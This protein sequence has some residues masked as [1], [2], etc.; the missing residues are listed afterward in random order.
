MLVLAAAWRDGRLREL[1]D[2]ACHFQ[3]LLDRTIVFLDDLAA[4]SPTCRVDREILVKLRS[5][6]FGDVSS[7]GTTACSDDGSGTSTW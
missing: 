2:R 7:E 1:V 6:L 5:L 4:M 3:A